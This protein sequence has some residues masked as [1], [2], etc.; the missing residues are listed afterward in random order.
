LFGL[1]F[2]ILVDFAWRV[3]GVSHVIVMAIVNRSEQIKQIFFITINSFTS[4][5]R[6]LRH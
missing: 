4:M 5:I 3:T 1:L 2:D 6:G